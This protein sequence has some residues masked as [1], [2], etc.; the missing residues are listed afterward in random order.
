MRT[1]TLVISA[2]HYPPQISEAQ[3]I[4]FQLQAFFLFFSAFF[5]YNPLSPV[6]AAHKYKSVNLTVATLRRTLTSRPI[7][8]TNCQ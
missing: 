2:P 6:C 7:T 1:C 3:Y 5:F 4:T 8:V